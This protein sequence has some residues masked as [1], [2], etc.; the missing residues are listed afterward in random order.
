MGSDLANCLF[1]DVSQAYN[2]KT[3]DEAKTLLDTNWK[4]KAFDLVGLYQEVFGKENFFIEIQRIDQINLPAAKVV[5]D[6]LEFIARKMGVLMVATADSH[7]ITRE[8]AQDQ[9]I[10]LCSLVGT[11]LS[12]VMS[13]IEK[14]DS[15]VGLA[16]FFRSNNYHIPTP[17]EMAALHTEEQIKN[18]LLIASMCEDF[19]IT[20]RPSVPRFDSPDGLSSEDYLRKLCRKGFKTRVRGHTTE[21]FPESAYVERITEELAVWSTT[22]ILCDYF[23]IVQDYVNAARA[24]GEPV[25]PSRGSGGGCLTNYFLGIT[26]MDPLY[27][28]LSFARFYNAGRNTKDRVSLPDIDSDF[29]NPG[30]VIEYIQNKY[31]RDKVARMGTYQRMMGRSVLKDVLRVHGAASAEEQNKI[32]EFIPDEAAIADQLQ[33]MRNEGVEPSI[34]K[35][36]LQDHAKEL[37]EW[38]YIDGGKLRGPL[39]KYFAQAIRLEGTKRGMSKHASGVIIADFVLDERIPMVRDKSSGDL[40]TG[41]PMEDVEAGGGAK[42]DVLGVQS[43]ARVSGVSRLLAGKRIIVTKGEFDD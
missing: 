21:E 41:V 12:H 10:L 34:I 37:K 25:G 8:S 15:D 3:Y 24:M 42:F 30:R 14:D 11:T 22:D 27:Y 17:E 7:Y 43:L 32:T 16:G 19:D 35:W 40:I 36:A 28:D 1:L 18:S 29:A 13:E 39:A 38:C 26:G 20:A 6:A 4:K 31:G 33:E 2:A 9:Q 23:L 5:A